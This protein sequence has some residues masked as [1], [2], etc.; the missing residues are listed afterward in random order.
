MK[1][2]AP[3]SSTISDEPRPAPASGVAREAGVASGDCIDGDLL[4][5]KGPA[6]QA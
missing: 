6:G 4:W 2:V 3:T 5:L 1:K